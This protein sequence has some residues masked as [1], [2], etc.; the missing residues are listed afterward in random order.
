MIAA[1]ARSAIDLIAGADDLRRCHRESVAAMR[2]A[3]RQRGLPDIP[4][5]SHIVPV[6]IGEAAACREIA[7]RLLADCRAY[8]QPINYP[9]VARGEERLRL[10]PGPAHGKTAIAD[11]ADGLARIWD[12]LGRA[13]EIR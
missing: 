12:A 7:R 9:T 1:G 4:N 6:P 2:L 11:F 13:R 3:L 5:D 10:T 8:V